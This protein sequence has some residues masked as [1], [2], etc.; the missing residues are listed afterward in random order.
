MD[1]VCAYCGSD[2]ATSETLLKRCSNDAC[3]YSEGDLGDWAVERSELVLLRF[4]GL[5]D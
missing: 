2:V 3:P 1:L 4:D 5:Q